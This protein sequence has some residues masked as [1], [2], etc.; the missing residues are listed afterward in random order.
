MVVGAGKAAAQMARAAERRFP[1]G[2][3]GLV[4]VPD[5]YTAPC[6]S[7]EVVKASHPLTDRRGVQA[8]AR[9]MDIVN[10]ADQGDT[11]VCLL[12]GG[13][14]A[15]L[16][17][18]AP[19]ISL[20]EKRKIVSAL[21]G[22]GASISELNCVRKH[23][24]A[25]K[26]GRLAEL[27]APARVL[28]LTVSDVVGN[29][30]SVIASGPT[31]PDPTTCGDALAV[32]RQYE[33]F[34]PTGI[35]NLLK[36]GASETPKILKT[37]AESHVVI[38]PENALTAAAAE[39]TRAGLNVHNLSD[40]CVGDAR[41]GAARHAAIV[42]SI[43]QGGGP[44]AAP[45]V[46]LSGGEYTVHVHGGGK[47]GPNTEFALALALELKAAANVW[48]LAADTDGSDGTSDAAGAFV[49]PTT[50]VRASQL[51]RDAHRDLADNNSATFFIAL[52]D[53]LTPG[54]TLTNV[55]D[56]R[57]IFVGPPQ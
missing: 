42:R 49:T 39:S 53:L 40:H 30:L 52:Q 14:S 54:P 16:A 11:V 9:I 36:S 5:G 4:I 25:V 45:C 18:P 51:G 7:V 2:L 22:A 34:I 10:K 31:V 15:L 38:R 43:V 27:A 48:A 29:D 57:A 26:G 50:L 32:L 19:G 55:N 17:A 13:A 23:L 8:T 21:M 47:G 1:S 41:Q 12:S 35:E 28:S 33:V 6:E 37:D 46:I 24:S 20:E 3:R 44:V 56:F